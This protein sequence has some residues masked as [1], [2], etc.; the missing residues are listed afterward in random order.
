MTVQPAFWTIP[1]DALD[2]GNIPRVGGGREP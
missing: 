1:R 2:D